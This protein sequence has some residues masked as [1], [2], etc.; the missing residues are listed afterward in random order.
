MRFMGVE[1]VKKNLEEINIDLN[2]NFYDE[3]IFDDLKDTWNEKYMWEAFAH[4]YAP[5]ISAEEFLNTFW[6]QKIDGKYTEL[7]WKKITDI[8]SG[9]ASLP[10]ELQDSGAKLSL[11]DPIFAENDTNQNEALNKNILHIE[12][13]IRLWKDCIDRKS[14]QVKEF[15]DTYQ[16]D[17]SYKW[18]EIFQ[19]GLP[20]INKEEEIISKIR[21]SNIK[22]EKLKD[23]LQ[24]RK[25]LLSNKTENLELHGSIWEN[26]S[27]IKDNSQDYVF[28]S[29][30]LDKDSVQ[31]ELIL[32]EAARILKPDGNIYMVHDHHE[33][34][35]RFLNKY[36]I[37][38]I[39]ENGHY[40]SVISK[41]YK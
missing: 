18:K 24:R 34:F 3:A 1:E 21:K 35:Q 9:F 11:V 8:W 39:E 29:C 41:K 13:D 40:I 10:F 12:R 14:S 15:Y 23:D 6:F 25:E 36:N 38:F 28:I 4:L 31:P 22:R 33:K 7:K 17:F 2:L 20:K 27:A 19:T 26:I 5:S 16:Y 30:V 32:A 37:P